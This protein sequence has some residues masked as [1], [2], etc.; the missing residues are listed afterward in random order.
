MSG[1]AGISLED[2]RRA[3]RVAREENVSIHA[4]RQ[5]NGS[6]TFIINPKGPRINDDAGDLDDRIASFGAN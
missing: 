5:P 4:T 6:I 3:S 1:R 2:L